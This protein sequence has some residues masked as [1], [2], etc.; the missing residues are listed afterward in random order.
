MKYAKT[1][2][3]T[4]TTATATRTSADSPPLTSALIAI[5]FAGLSPSLRKSPSRH[6]RMI[7]RPRVNLPARKYF[8]P[9]IG[10]GEGAGDDFP[11]IK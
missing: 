2:T 3:M 8:T 9:H 7:Y 6:S 10:E 5:K 11:L 1:T 4:T